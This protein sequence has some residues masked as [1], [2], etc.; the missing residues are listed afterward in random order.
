MTSFFAFS[1]YD[2]L[3]KE[4]FLLKLNKLLDWEKIE[5]K[6]KGL[7]ERVEKLSLIS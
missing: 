3:G 1:A 7:Y 4:N 6:L 2:R 5:K